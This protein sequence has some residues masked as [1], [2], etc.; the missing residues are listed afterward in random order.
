MPESKEAKPA[1][2]ASADRQPST[3]KKSVYDKVLSEAEKADFRNVR[4]IEG[5]DDEIALFRV[6]I[7]AILAE[8]PVKVQL[9]V[10]ATDL[11][12]RL[13]K[14][15]YQ[16]TAKQNKGLEEAIRNVIKDVGVPLGVAILN[17]KL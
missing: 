17:K 2:T 4:G 10:A 8:E 16:I 9:L 12:A 5:I 3:E 13:V 15:R 11:L 7:K 1:K 6:K 14:T